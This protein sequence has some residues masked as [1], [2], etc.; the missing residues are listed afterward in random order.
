LVLLL[1]F[2]FTYQNEHINIV[3]QQLD[4]TKTCGVAFKP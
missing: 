3:C 1:G 2:S 4:I